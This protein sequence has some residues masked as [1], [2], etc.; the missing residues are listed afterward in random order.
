MTDY[1]SGKTLSQTPAADLIG[2]LEDLARAGSSDDTVEIVR[3][4]ARRLIGADVIFPQK[5]GQG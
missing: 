4:K 5:S 2:A 3:S 1:R